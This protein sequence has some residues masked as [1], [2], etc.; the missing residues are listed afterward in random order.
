MTS[1]ILILA[2]GFWFSGCM[3]MGGMGMHS[4]HMN[5]QS[6]GAGTTVERAYTDDLLAISIKVPPLIVYQPSTLEVKILKKTEDLKSFPRF[7]IR[8][9]EDN[10]DN[11]E[12]VEIPESK[13]IELSSPG[14][15]PVQF[16]PMETGSADISVEMLNGSERTTVIRFS[17]DVKWNS[18]SDMTSN[19]TQY[20]LLGGAV[21]GVMMS[22]MMFGG[23]M[24]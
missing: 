22:V 8:I 24:F 19:N 9:N 5:H 11:I 13:T 20:Y 23:Q 2:L 18:E 7:I 1:K 16:T 21:M 14:T 17:T 3:L 4:G 12:S 15:F 6:T 10:W